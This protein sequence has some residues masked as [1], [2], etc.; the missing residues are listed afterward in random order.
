[1]TSTLPQLDNA[2]YTVGWI[3]ALP[4]ERIAAEAMLDKRHAPPQY[5][6]PHDHNTYT[7]GSIA[8]PD[9]DHN[10][11]I[12]S[13]P[14][15]R[16]GTTPA[17][18]FASQMLSSF[19]S[20]QLGLM[21]GIGGGI[22]SEHID[23]RLGD[24]AVSRPE[25]VYGG[26]RQYDC[27]RRTASGFEECGFLSPPPMA[28]LNAIGILESKHEMTGS[29]MPAI[30]EAAYEADPLLVCPEQGYSYTYPGDN[31][32][33]LF[34]ASYEHPA[35]RDDCTKCDSNEEVNRSERP[36]DGPFVHYGTIASGNMVVKDARA[37]EMLAGNCIC[38]EMEAA[39]MM[40]ILPSLV[41]RGICD[42]SDS[43]KNDRWQNYAAIVAAAYAKE[44][45]QVTNCCRPL[46]RLDGMYSYVLCWSFTCLMLSAEYSAA[47]PPSPPSLDSTLMTTTIDP[48]GLTPSPIS[49]DL[50]L[51]DTSLTTHDWLG[52]FDPSRHLHEVKAARHPGTGSWFLRSDFF[53]KWKSGMCRHLWLHGR[54]GSGKTILSSTVIEHLLEKSS[55]HV[56]LYFFFSYHDTDKRD[57][58]GLVSSLV[59]Q[60]STQSESSRKELDTMRDRY[61]N[62]SPRSGLKQLLEMFEQMVRHTKNVKIAIDGLDECQNRGELLSWIRVSSE[63]TKLQFLLTS[64]AKEDIRV[65]FQPWLPTDN[66]VST[67][68]RAMKNDIGLYV[69]DQLRDD[70][71]FAR[72]R[73]REDIQQKIKRELVRKSKGV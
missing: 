19:P 8:G 31:Y 26:V 39:G 70:K 43:H 47:T 66:W 23:I 20:I 37:R 71:D 6:H 32:D 56:L 27:G 36:D 38:Y 5:I 72:W 14:P 55:S 67:Q 63:N 48:E 73:S 64:R 52:I 41:I 53:Q 30:L 28:L 59:A 11:V 61:D 24:V 15:T 50:I 2:D 49:G 54:A 18:V 45:L 21:V 65:F 29:A 51:T 68:Q 4:H 7:L 12:I 40:N 17:A 60:L 16:Y 33:R 57:L 10:I 44:I 46:M 42:Y 1:M 34:Q 9:G 3:T 25:G 35:G 69:R 22:P 58:G 13:F 62:E